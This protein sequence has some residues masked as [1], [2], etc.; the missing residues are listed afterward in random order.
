MSSDA[1]A[2]MTDDGAAAVPPAAA[3]AAPAGPREKKRSPNR[4]IVDESH[5]E[6]DNSVVM[7]SLAKMEELSLFRGDTVLIRGKKKHETVCVAIM[8]ESVDA[9]CRLRR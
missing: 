3:A 4:L 6:G 1:P 2:P 8:D 7:L 5:G 9:A